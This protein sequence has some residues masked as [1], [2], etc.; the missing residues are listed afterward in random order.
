MSGQ[1]GS[2]WAVGTGLR[3]VLSFVWAVGSL[4]RD[5]HLTYL[6]AGV[7][8]YAFV[9]LIPLVL[10]AVAVASL[11]G[12]SVFADRVVTTLG[13]YLSSSGQESVTRMLTVTAG[14]EVASV[15]GF[16]TLAWSGSRL[17]RALDIA[18]DEMYVD[19]VETPL[20]EQVGNALVV[21][22]GIGAAVAVAVVAGIVVSVLP[23]GAPLAGPLGAAALVAVLALALLPV[24]Y[25]LPPVDVSLREVL[26]G[27][28]VAAVG[29]VLLQAGF[30]VYAT[31][32]GRYGAYGIVGAILLFVTWLYFASIVV[33][34]GGAV[35]AVYGNATTSAP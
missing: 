29:W 10:L 23:W 9:S 5:R 17:F 24:Y 35:N 27:A 22:L 12:G 28:L 30:G 11:V 21:A 34:V 2:E 14:R 15:V 13:R 32:A 4:V 33:L 6:A 7:A 3:D 18:F 20:L 16:L 26:P 8:Y 19:D 31:T 25:V 1:S